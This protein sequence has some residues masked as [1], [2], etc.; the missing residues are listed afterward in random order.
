MPEGITYQ[1]IPFSGKGDDDTRVVEGYVSSGEVDLDQQIVDQGWLKRELPVWLARFG[2]IREQHDPQRAV[3]KAQSVDL[4]AAPGPYL[5]A[6]IVDDEAW[7]KVK[8]GV[9]NGFSVGIKGPQIVRD[10]TA[11]NGRIVGG[12]L[13]EVSVVDRPANDAAKFTLVKRVEGGWKDMQS[14]AVVEGTSL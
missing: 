8:E 3:G 1:F 10:A 2:N 13:I 6:K 12:T 4:D 14:G 7:R 5:A 11:R 9:Y